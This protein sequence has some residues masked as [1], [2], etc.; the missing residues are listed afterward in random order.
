M[1]I[2]RE[3]KECYN[4]EEQVVKLVNEV[5]ARDGA[6]GA[7]LGG[8]VICVTEKQRSVNLKN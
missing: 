7:C 4:S 2:K 6:N 5:T 3:Q 8:S 1:T